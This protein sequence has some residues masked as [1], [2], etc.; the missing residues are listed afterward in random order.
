MQ[1]KF[2]DKWV[3]CAV[4]LSWVTA[5]CGNG[6]GTLNQYVQT[7][8]AIQPGLGSLWLSSLSSYETV[9]RR[10]T[11]WHR[12][13][14]ADQRRELTESTGGWLLW[15]GYSKVGTTL[16]KMS[17]SERRLCREVADRCSYMLKIENKCVCLWP[18]GRSVNFYSDRNRFKL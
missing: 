5:M 17:T 14:A 1:P 3:M 9:S 4:K 7:F 18:H 12:Q 6:A 16:W 15:R 11:F 8:M 13:W 2:I 10:T